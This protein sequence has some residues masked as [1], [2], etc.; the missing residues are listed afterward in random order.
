MDAPRMQPQDCGQE[1]EEP[2]RCAPE[3]EVA[4]PDEGEPPDPTALVER[5]LSWYKKTDAAYPADTLPHMLLSRDDTVHRCAPLLLQERDHH[6]LMAVVS[7]PGLASCS[8]KNEARCSRETKRWPGEERLFSEDGRKFP[9]DEIQYLYPGSLSY[10][11]HALSPP[12]LPYGSRDLE[13][14]H[15]AMVLHMLIPLRI[16]SFNG[17]KT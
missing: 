14:S 13:P 15:D 8:S 3:P 5:R 16:V 6:H 9:R 2:T 10:G 4:P 7:L 1:Q 12:Q 11:R 17:I